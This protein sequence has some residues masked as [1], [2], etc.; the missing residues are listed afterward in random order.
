[1][2]K[3]IAMIAA[4]SMV[5][6]IGLTCV[7]AAEPDDLTIT[8]DVTELT[9]SD[10]EDIFGE[11][12]GDNIGYVL[13]FSIEGLEDDLSWNQSGSGS[14]RVYTGRSLD[15]AALTLVSDI[16]S[17]NIYSAY[18]SEDGAVT[19]E[20]DI[21]ATTFD[22]LTM[23][24][25]GTR[26]LPAAKNV[27]FDGSDY[28]IF[29]IA[30]PQGVEMNLTPQGTIKINNW[31]GGKSFASSNIYTNETGSNLLFSPAVITLG[32][33]APPAPADEYIDSVIDVKKPVDGTTGLTDL[34]NQEVTLSSNYGIAKFQPVLDTD[35]KNYFLVATDSADNVKEFAIDFAAKGIEISNATTTFFAIVKSADRII[36]NIRLKAVTKA[37]E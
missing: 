24:V 1:M 5:A 7:S 36:K 13:N 29:Y 33:S 3:I 23:E 9:G 2:K 4:L 6:S 35:A 25:N 18:A 14:N 8:C 22:G 20:N 16:D 17:S 30:I 34:K 10:Y 19:T 31:E 27:T 11:E 15:A 37:A 12:Q 28:I 26:M 32:A 21:V